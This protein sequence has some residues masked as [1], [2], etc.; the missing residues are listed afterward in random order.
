MLQCA[1]TAAGADVVAVAT[2]ANSVAWVQVVVNR[3]SLCVI[4]VQF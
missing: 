4:N 1:G 2:A 3:R